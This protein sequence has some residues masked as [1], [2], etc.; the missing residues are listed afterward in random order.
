[1]GWIDLCN[2]CKH[3][4]SMPCYF[5]ILPVRGVYCM[6]NCYKLIN[7]V[8]GYEL[9]LDHSWAL[10]SSVKVCSIQKVLIWKFYSMKR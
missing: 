7:S 5:T 3:D 2:I 9:R 6:I 1:M 10:I 8:A 4:L